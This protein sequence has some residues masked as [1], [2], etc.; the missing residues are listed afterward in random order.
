[1]DIVRVLGCKVNDDTFIVQRV[2]TMDRLVA[3]PLAYETEALEGLTI[4]HLQLVDIKNQNS[5]YTMIKV[6]ADVKQYTSLT[7]AYDEEHATQGSRMSQP[8]LRDDNTPLVM[9]VSNEEAVKEADRLL[10]EIVRD[11]EGTEYYSDPSGKF[12][13]DKIE[14][15]RKAISNLEFSEMSAFVAKY[16]AKESDEWSP[17]R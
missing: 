14:M 9:D 7:Y 11:I 16:L 5:E 1:M 2:K 10:M 8:G 13:A 3:K 4:Q 15:L 17:V 6:P 12:V